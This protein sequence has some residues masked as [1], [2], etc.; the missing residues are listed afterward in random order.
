[1][2]KASAGI[3]SHLDHLQTKF[4]DPVCHFHLLF[5]SDKDIAFDRIYQFIQQTSPIQ[6]FLEFLT[7][8]Q[9]EN[10]AAT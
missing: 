5:L 1:M 4:Y 3:V 8:S 10:L 6:P 9:Q 2:Q 7:Q